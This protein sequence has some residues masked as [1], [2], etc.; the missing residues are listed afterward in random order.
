[1]SDPFEEPD[2]TTPL[3]PPER[4]ELIPAHIAYRSELNEAKQ[5]NI[6]HAHDWALGRRRDHLNEKFH[7]EAIG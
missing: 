1:V 4:R 6:V 5:E 7:S 3:T 2:N